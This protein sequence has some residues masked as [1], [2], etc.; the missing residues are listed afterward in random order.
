MNHL[1]DLLKLFA[2]TYRHKTL[3]RYMDRTSEERWHEWSGE[4]LAD[5]A[6]LAAQALA[7]AG[8]RPGDRVALYTQNMMEGIITELGLMAMRAVCVPLYATCSPE[9]VA[10]IT[11]HAGCELIFVGEQFQYNNVYPL[12]ATHPTPRQMVILDERVVRDPAD[13]ASEYFDTFL[14]M[15]DAMSYETAVRAQLGAGT[16]DETAVIIYTSGTTGLPKGV[17]I[18]HRMIL[19]QVERHQQLFPTMGDHDVSVNFLPL[20][21]VFEK[22]WVYFCLS[23]AIKVVVVTNPKRIMEL[24]PQI[25]PTAMCNV[26]RYWEK[27][28]QGVQEH[29]SQAKPFMQRIYQRA[30]RVGHKYHIGY[31]IHG[32]KAPWGLRLSN[33]LYR[34]TVF[35]ILKRVLGLERGRFYPTAG[36]PLSDEINEF[37]QSAGFNIVVGYGLSESAATVSCYPP[38][39]FVIGSVGDVIP[40]VEVRIDPETQ[41]IQLRGDSITPGYYRNEEANAAAFTSDGWFRTGDAGHLEGRTLY[42]TERIKELYKTSNGKYI[43]PQQIEALLSSSPLIEQCAVVADE[44]KFVSALIYPNYEQ[45]RRRLRERGQ[46]ELAELSDEALSQSREL[47]DMLLSHI[48]PLQAHLAGFEKVKRVALLATPFTI[49]A[50][51]LT[52]TLKLRRK[53]ILEQYAGVIEKLYL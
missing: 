14:S 6:M 9:Q 21:H 24:M 20:S 12:L 3:L 49:E 47:C 31:R 38:K 34:Y 52:P 22:L 43:S 41:E 18:T 45:L 19:T 48:E 46:S 50:G 40:G 51:T 16:P 35:Y 13:D 36:A 33:A 32:R 53:A 25:R 44:R 26:P 10:Y 29:I 37:L 42:F 5:Q 11:E 8:V 15:G 28:Y 39:Q 17:I 1:G 7:R 23:T 2:T 4:Q 27:V 30:L